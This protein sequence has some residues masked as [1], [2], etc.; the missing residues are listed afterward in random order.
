MLSALVER[1]LSFDK[2]HGWQ[3]VVG[4]FMRLRPAKTSKDL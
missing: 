4:F 1:K 3:A 2:T